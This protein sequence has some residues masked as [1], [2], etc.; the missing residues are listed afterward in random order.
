MESISRFSKKSVILGSISLAFLTGLVV[1][2]GQPISR[3]ILGI[4]TFDLKDLLASFDDTS[5]LFKTNRI[6]SFAGMIGDDYLVGTLSRF[7]CGFLSEETV[8]DRSGGYQTIGFFPD[9]T[10][11]K[12]SKGNYTFENGICRQSMEAIA[13]FDPAGDLS[14]G[15]DKGMIERY[16]VS[17]VTE[18]A[19]KWISLPRCAQRPDC[20]SFRSLVL[21]RKWFLSS[22]LA[23]NPDN[24]FCVWYYIFERDAET[25]FPRQDKLV[26]K[27]LIHGAVDVMNDTV[28]ILET[29]DFMQKM[30]HQLSLG[31]DGLKYVDVCVSRTD[32]TPLRTRLFLY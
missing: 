16:G 13:T 26:A 27:T 32:I 7:Q 20:C 23:K 14:R 19:S 31:G 12:L 22:C 11:A 18:R 30:E 15:S 2:D 10:V 5:A 25:R 24:T 4:E 17:N 21:D 28:N 8:Y 3:T 1:A 9:Q 6:A 29:V